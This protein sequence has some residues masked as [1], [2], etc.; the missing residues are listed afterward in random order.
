VIVTNREVGSDVVAE[1]AETLLHGLPQ[2]L[3][4]LE[5]VPVFG[6]MDASALVFNLG[7]RES[8]FPPGC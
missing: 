1:F 4:G 2:R 8:P 6:G 5:T 7:M 3:Q